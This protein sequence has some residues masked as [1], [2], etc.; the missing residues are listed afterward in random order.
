MKHFDENRRA[1][2]LGLAATSA[3]LGRSPLARA[4]QPEAPPLARTR[5]GQVQ[6]FHRNGAAVFLGVPYG[7][8]TAGQGRFRP[9]APPVPWA[10]VRDATRLG[11]RSPQLA[12]PFY[13]NPLFG[14]YL[15]GGRA[16][17]LMSQ[18]RMG[19]DCLVLNVLTPR[20]DNKTRPVMVYF[21]G[22][23]FIVNS[24]A[25]N[26]LGDR[27][28][29][30]EDVVL[31]T[32]NHRL[33]LLGFMYL[34]ELSPAYKQGNVGLLDLVTALNWIR[35]NVAQFGG[36]PGR[37]T[38][39]GDSGGGA[40]VGALLAMP[41]AKGLFHRA[42]MES[43]GD[44]RPLSIEQASVMTRS[45]LTK[46]S[47]E[48][49][50]LSSLQS[51]SFE[52]LTAATS[53]EPPFPGPVLDDATLHS[54]F[55]NEGAPSTASD[56]PLIIGACADEETLFTG[57]QNPDLFTIA[58]ADVPTRLAT[59]TGRSQTA[60]GP[61]IEAYRRVYPN[62]SA[63]DIVFRMLSLV[64]YGLG[65]IGREVATA[66]AAQRAPVFYYRN[67][68]DTRIAPGLRAFH[69]SELPLACRLVADPRAEHLSR[70]IA[71]AWAAFAR[72]GNPNHGGLPHWAR[73]E[74]KSAGPMILF[75]EITRTVATDP[76]YAAQRLLLDVL[77][78]PAAT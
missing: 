73:Y 32:V 16:T 56:I 45:V 29:V 4:A 31:I 59:L 9:P 46:L 6:G 65:R 8:S 33:G 57:M 53:G 62:E 15:T 49:N 22:G 55:W 63:V 13:S 48:P 5:Y 75:N 64:G 17:E 50:D 71:G 41:E 39:F 61:S 18:E 14:N 26:T 69:T 35:N 44:L 23:G 34:G 38:I 54:P 21:H 27:L 43:S 67:E 24:G 60:L 3:F 52:K 7:A 47:I 12:E 37:V 36:D 30:E 1:V 19:E 76:E 74:P 66:K 78:G 68:F 72:T 20:V 11:P 40:K 77:K 51:I 70:Q 58:W 28:V 2:C 10:D 42:I 25:I